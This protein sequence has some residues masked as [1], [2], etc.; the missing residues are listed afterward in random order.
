MAERKPGP[1]KPPVI[2]LTAR[3]ATEPQAPDATKPGPRT[4][5]ARARPAATA[6]QTRAPGPDAKPDA[7][8]PAPSP[9]QGEATEPAGAASP[10][11]SDLFAERS[12]EPPPPGDAAAAP[13][14]PET[15]GPVAGTA[16]DEPVAWAPAEAA[17]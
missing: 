15:A 10:S 13:A 11:T 7:A 12:T 2:D 4:R 5:P 6:K 14:E 1:V 8:P 9:G 16:P 3:E 17:T